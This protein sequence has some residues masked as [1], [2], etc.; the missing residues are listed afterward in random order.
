MYAGQSCNYSVAKTVP[1]LT[2]L[3]QNGTFKL[4]QRE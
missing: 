2:N 4:I 3:S 1:T